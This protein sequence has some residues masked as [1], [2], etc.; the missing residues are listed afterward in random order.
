MLARAVRNTQVTVPVDPTGFEPS[1]SRCLG[2]PYVGLIHAAFSGPG[3]RILRQVGCRRALP[4]GLRPVRGD[5]PERLAHA[6]QPHRGLGPRPGTTFDL[7]RRVR[8]SGL[9]GLPDWHG[10][11]GVG[12]VGRV[13]TLVLLP[14]R[15]PAGIGARGSAGSDGG[16]SPSSPQSTW[17][18]APARTSKRRWKPAGSGSLAASRA[19]FSRI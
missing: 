13:S 16:S 9:G 11:S 8:S 4:W 12:I 7:D 10:R 18:W 2:Q 14:V 1:Y 3:I 19:Q 5:L 6:D 15:M 17:A